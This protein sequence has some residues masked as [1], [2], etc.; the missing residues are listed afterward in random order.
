MGGEGDSQVIN[1]L[2]IDVEECFQASEVQK[3]S[4]DPDSAAF[5]SRVESQTDQVLEILDRMRTRATFFIVGSVAEQHPK[6]VQRIAIAGHE[7]G[8]H[9]HAHRLVYALTPDEFR[10]D[11]LRSIRAIED[12]CGIRPRI[13]RAPSY[14]IT[15]RS[16]WA[17]EVLAECGFTHDS[18]V[19]P[20]H[21]D[22]YGIPGFDRH[23]H[24]VNTAAGPI[25]EI[26]VG[27][28]RLSVKTVAPVGGGGYLRLLPYRYTAAG[29]RRVNQS[30]M[31]PV[32]VY[33]HP[34]ELDNTQTRIAT[35]TIA[36]IRTYA[37]LAGMRA[38]VV[39]LLQEF[40]FDSMQAVYGEAKT[41]SPPGLTENTQG[42]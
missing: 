15:S 32:C 10:A 8:C 21:H 26:P 39:R 9:S 5:E 2:S 19:Y 35:G 28:V 7:I 6:M 1:A 14:S 4:L 40:R 34:W 17:L 42:R 30:E 29:I 27:T 24:I 23:A 25:H 16:L 3:H 38:K 13:Y 11:T 20:I 12:A 37:G 22:R 36:R 18:S 31:Q 33:F 41:P